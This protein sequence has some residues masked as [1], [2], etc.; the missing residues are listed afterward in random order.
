MRILCLLTILIFAASAR[1]ED[2]QPI[3][4]SP[5][6]RS[7]PTLTT[8]QSHLT[9]QPDLKS[10]IQTESRPWETPLLVEKSTPNEISLGRHQVDGIAI[11]LINTDNPLQLINPAAPERY[12][13]ADNNVVP[14]ISTRK[15]SGLKLL[16]FQF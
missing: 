4:L 12:G 3:A 11:Q 5:T 7:I 9:L 14:D 16:E 10:T 6:D 15:A 1:A 13:S 8:A 2:L